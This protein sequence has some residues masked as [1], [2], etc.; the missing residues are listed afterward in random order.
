MFF[1]PYT[2]CHKFNLLGGVG[3]STAI[4]DAIAV[5]NRAYSLPFNPNVKDIDVTFKEYKKECS[6]LVESALN[7]SGTIRIMTGQVSPSN[8]A[9][10]SIATKVI[11]D[12]FKFVLASVKR[13]GESCHQLQFA[14]LP[15]VGDVGRYPPEYKPSLYVKAPQGHA[16]A[17]VLGSDLR[18]SASAL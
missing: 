15:L 10:R 6:S 9:S 3:A 18:H 14:F 8:S 2:P 11:Q 16:K 5:A 1:I 4:H 12:I 13:K 7:S 17:A